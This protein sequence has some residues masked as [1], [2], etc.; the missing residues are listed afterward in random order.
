MAV[1]NQDELARELLQQLS[2]MAE[3]AAC[4]AKEMERANLIRLHEQF[5]GQL[6]RAIDDPSLAAALSTLTGLSEERRRQMIFANKQYGLILLA[7]RVGVLDRAEL[8]G[9]LKVLSRNPVFVEYW[10]RTA[11]QRRSLP[12]E[13]FE[14]RVGRAVDAIMEERPD[15]LDDWWVV[16]PEEGHPDG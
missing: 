16:T 6:D 15:D 12:A 13:S 7:H 9:A 8:L 11:E 14:A 1:P 10:E 2:R 3:A 4:M 5:L